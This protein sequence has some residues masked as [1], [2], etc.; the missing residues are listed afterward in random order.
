MKQRPLPSL[1]V[2]VLA[3]AL[4][5]V[6]SGQSHPDFTGTWTVQRVDVTNAR[7]A[8][9]DRR[10]DGGGYGRRGGR[11]GRGGFGGFGGGG[12]GRGGQRGQNRGD[13]PR[14]QPAV[15]R[16]GDVVRITQT[17]E[18]LILTTDG[19]EGSVMTSYTLDGK[20]AKNHPTDDVEIKSKT[21]WEGVALV[22]NSTQSVSTGRG[23]FSIKTREIRTL[24][25]DQQTMTVETTADTPGGKRTSTA[26]LT[27]RAE[28]VPR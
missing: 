14:R 23:N 19:P 18:R 12:G 7:S 17:S 13:Q 1:L 28:A 9:A 8:D 6:S 5:S 26:T 10:G 25:D 24:G 4:G 2:L 15:L 22:T 11:G 16:E 27:K 3:V 20:E 21:T